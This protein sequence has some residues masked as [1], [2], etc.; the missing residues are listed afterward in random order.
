MSCRVVICWYVVWCVAVCSN[1]V[2][3]GVVCACDCMYARAFEWSYG[4]THVGTWACV[5][6][7]CSYV[8][9]INRMMAYEHVY[10]IIQVMCENMEM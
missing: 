8:L 10:V 2:C 1:A 7:A 6:N 5:V 4:R 9:H 3:C